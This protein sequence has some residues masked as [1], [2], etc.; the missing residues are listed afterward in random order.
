MNYDQLQRIEFLIRTHKL[1]EAQKRIGEMLPQYPDEGV[2]YQLQS[3]IEVEK[4]NYNRALELINTSI[5]LE[6]DDADNFYYKSRILY[7][8]KNFVEAMKSIDAALNIDPAEPYYCGQKALL[9]YQKEKRQEAIQWAKK[10][11]VTNPD[12]ELCANVLSMVLG[13]TGDTLG[14]EAVLGQRLEQNPEDAF[15]HANMGYNFI[16]KGNMQ[17]AKVHFKEA[18]VL[19]PEFQYAKDGM[20]DAIK[21]SNPLYRTIINYAVWMEQKTSKNQW[22]IIIGL[23]VVVRFLPFLLVPYLIFVAYIWLAPPIAHAVLYYDTYGRYLMDTQSR[24]I[25]IAINCLL[26]IALIAAIFGF[27]VSG[28]YFTLAV[29]ALFAAV[30]VYGLVSRERPFN[31]LMLTLFAAAFLVYGI[32]SALPM[33]ADMQQS[34]GFMP[35]IV[36]AVIY[37]W[38]SN[39]FQE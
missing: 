22:L 14:A 13:S 28:T 38:V 10:G 1:E 29:A 16:R 20:I 37:T 21:G 5:G 34:L 4:D 9:L 2:L 35:I 6:P 17:Q 32:L 33:F 36:I 31:Q 27:I 24:S 30:P 18:L 12:N 26:P 15:T 8:K 23:I 11:L 7:L 19:D 3:R 39:I 25:S